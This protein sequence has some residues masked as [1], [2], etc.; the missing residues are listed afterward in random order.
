MDQKPTVAVIIPV[1][2]ESSVVGEAL[3][4]FVSL[5]AD[6]VIVVDGKSSDGTYEIVKRG[7]PDVMCHQAAFPERS[8]QM[9]LGAS[10]SKSDVFIFAHIDMRLPVDTVD[11]IRQRIQQGFIG[12]GFKKSYNPS[13]GLLRVYIYLL[14]QL[15]L[16]RMHCLVGTN[17]IFVT[18]AIF[19]RMKGFSEVAFLE[20]MMFS[21]CLKKQ[22]RIAIIDHPVIVSSRKYFKNGVVRQILRNIRIVLGYKLLH[23]SP[24]KLRAMYQG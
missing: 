2:N 19:E 7:F 21:E 6:E 11:V 10:K 17:A 16:I 15:Y 3:K 13:T 18:R 9:N 1:H 22:G 20:D 8:L 23:E 14:N 12:G 24:V 4:H 5:G